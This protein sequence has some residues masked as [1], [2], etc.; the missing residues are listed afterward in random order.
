VELYAETCPHY[1]SLTSECPVGKVGPP[2]R[3]KD[4]VEALWSAIKSGIIS[5]IGSDHAPMTLEKKKGKGDVWSMGLGQCT[6][7]MLLPVMLHEG[8]NKRQVPLETIVRITS[9]NPARILNMKEK[10]DIEV[11][12]DADIVIVDLKKKVKVT[13]DILHSFAG[14]TP[15][16]GWEFVGWPAMTIS[17]GIVVAEEGQVTGKPGH[18]R[19]V[20]RP[21][22]NK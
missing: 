3:T 20:R 15:Y 1:I 8:F 4:D 19:T 2:L 21:P 9:R 16:D 18:G 6:G 17:R 12:K 11:G 13:P 14:W 10:G 5:T 22:R 7:E